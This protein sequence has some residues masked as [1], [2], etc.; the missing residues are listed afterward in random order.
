MEYKNTLPGYRLPNPRLPP[1]SNEDSKTIKASKIKK[2]ESLVKEMAK[3]PNRTTNFAAILYLVESKFEKMLLSTLT[4]RIKIDYNKDKEIF[5]NSNTKKP[6]ESEIK[7]LRNIIQALKRNKSFIIKETKGDKYISLDLNN[8]L[9]YLR[10][11]YQKYINDE[12]DVS[13]LSSARSPPKI[14]Y[15]S[16]KKD[17]KLLGN[18]TLR[19]KQKKKFPNQMQIDS[20]DLDGFEPEE[21]SLSTYKFLKENLK[22]KTDQINNIKKIKSKE[23]EVD[24]IFDKDFSFFI[25]GYSTENF[26]SKHQN[27]I[28]NSLNS[29]EESKNIIISYKKKL[30]NFQSKVEERDKELE[31]FKEV[32][33]KLMKEKNELKILY[34]VL[35]LKYEIVKNTKNSK[36]FGLIFEK[37][38][39]NLK[40]YKVVT[41]SKIKN[42]KLFLQDTLSLE[43]NIMSKD[44]DI[45]HDASP[46]KSSNNNNKNLDGEN[47]FLIRKDY[48]N[49]LKSIK[50]NYIMENYCINDYCGE[51][52]NEIANMIEEK[53]DE[54]WKKIKDE[55]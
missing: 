2:I 41:D 55:K 54:L 52:N 53:M 11:M 21:K 34:Q 12:L 13:S 39:K 51:N 29:V 37:N 9:E 46:V 19:K 17:K 24:N 10:K 49:L 36:Y 28:T 43:K 44:K 15:N 16:E 1:T 45:F 5:I 40:L 3:R 4:Q 30:K 33:N 7:A 18:K 14:A 8:T 22:P 35:E 27:D 48:S 20:Y 6:F 47:E 42:F 38:K 31:D 23:K 50:E 26:A 25:K 32:Q